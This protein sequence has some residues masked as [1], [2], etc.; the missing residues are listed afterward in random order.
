WFFLTGQPYGREVD[1]ADPLLRPLAGPRGLAEQA[2]KDRCACLFRLAGGEE[3]RQ[4]VTRRRAAA[5]ED[6]EGDEEQDDFAALGRLCALA[7]RAWGSAAFRRG[8]VFAHPVIDSSLLHAIAA[9]VH[10]QARERGL[11]RRRVVRREVKHVPV[12]V[13]RDITSRGLR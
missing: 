5:G 1:A 6:D 8:V 2:S 4:A 12:W 10:G 13:C 7:F 11:E 9:K 3:P